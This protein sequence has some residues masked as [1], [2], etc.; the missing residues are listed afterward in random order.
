MVTSVGNLMNRSHPPSPAFDAQRSLRSQLSEAGKRSD[1]LFQEPGNSFFSQR[2]EH[3]MAR[4]I[5]IGLFWQHYS[6]N[7]GKRPF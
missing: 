4:M 1:K 6:T 2:K 3:T 5:S 7:F